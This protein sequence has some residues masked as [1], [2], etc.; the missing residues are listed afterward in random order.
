MRK[1]FLAAVAVFAVS[2][3]SYAGGYLTNT[4][5]SASFLRNPA[6]LATFELDGAYSNPAGLAWIGEG[7]HFMFNW[8][9]AA[10]TRKITSTFAPFAQNV[11]QLGNPTKTFNGEASAPFIPSLDVAYQ[12]G[13]FTASMHFGITGGGGKATFNEGL[14]MFEAPVS[15]IPNML[16]AASIPADAYS[17]EMY[18]NGRQ[19]I[20][21]VQVGVTYKFFENKGAAKHGLSMHLGARMNFASNHYEGYLKNISARMGGNMVVLSPFFSNQSSELMGKAEQATNASHQYTLLADATTDEALKAQ[22]QAMAAQYAAG[23]AQ[24]QAGAQTMAGLSQ[25]TADM[26]LDCD[27][28]G[29]GIAPIIGLD[30][31]V[32]NLNIGARYE[33]QTNM[34]IENKTTVNTTGVESFAHGVNTPNDI[35]GILAIG[36]QYQVL[37]KWRLMAGWNCYFDKKAGMSGGKQ[38]TLTHNTHEITVGTEVDVVDRLTLSGGFQNTDYGT[39]DAFQSDLSFNCDSYSLGFG[40]KVK[41]TKKWTANAAYFWTT[42]KDYTKASDNYNGTG[43]PGV[44]VY[45]RTNKVFG[46]GITYDL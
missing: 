32:G 19:Y 38:K 34:N 41:I 20:Y 16:S 23:A 29:W 39:S 25:K 18:M 45:S 37:P 30:Y 44:D 5:Q 2:A 10:Q 7:W 21:G 43:L 17:A 14:P 1:L 46:V 36:A 12:K 31:R 4:N 33:F 24:A 26:E 9:N 8:Q 13:K 15:V 28:K 3:S 42:Y 40:L 22:Y 27:Q 35:P 11:N 6:R